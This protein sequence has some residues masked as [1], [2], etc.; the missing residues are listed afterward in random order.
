[1]TILS[2]WFPLY[3]YNII[4]FKDAALSFRRVFIFHTLSAFYGTII[5]SGIINWLCRALL[6]WKWEINAFIAQYFYSTRNSMFV[7]ANNKRNGRQRPLSKT[8][9][10][11]VVE[12][13]NVQRVA[14]G[15]NCTYVP[16][17]PRCM[18]RTFPRWPRRQVLLNWMLTPA[19]VTITIIA[20]PPAFPVSFARALSLSSYLPLH[21]YLDISQEVAPDNRCDR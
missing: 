16:L 13:R 8:I 14:P 5:Y 15:C 3:L 6:V 12:D 2:P 21:F 18:T 19:P 20:F 11:F 9:Y 17:H 1:M 7:T 10:R 4:L